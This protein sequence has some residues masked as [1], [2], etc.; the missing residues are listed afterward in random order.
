MKVLR[1]RVRFPTSPPSM[2]MHWLRRGKIVK[3]TTGK[4]TNLI[5]AKLVNANEDVYEMALAA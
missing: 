1:T 3:Q 5:R 2:G 4:A